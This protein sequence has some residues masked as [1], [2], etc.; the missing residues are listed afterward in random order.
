[1]PANPLKGAS[2]MLSAAR[3]S[4]CPP[5]DGC[6]VAFAGRS[7]AGKSSAI[8]RLVEQRSLART[9]GTPGRTQLI[10]FF[11]VGAD[12][13]ARLVDLPGYGYAKVPPAV[14]AKWAAMIEGYFS[15]RESLAGIVLIMDA[16]HPMKPFDED[17]LSFAEALGLPVH[18]LM[19]KADKLKRGEQARQ[20][21]AVRRALPERVTVQLFSALKGQGVE[22]ARSVVCEWLGLD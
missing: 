15:G 19:T 10:N 18:V 6:E 12:E 17:L 8:N 16:R 1:M 20:L 4:Q 11:A 5:D 7:N 2:F 3:P 9:S 22:D 14:K 21:A 13:H